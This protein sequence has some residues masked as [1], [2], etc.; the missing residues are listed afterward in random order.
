M[1]TASESMPTN[2]LTGDLPRLQSLAEAEQ[3]SYDL[4]STVKEA[5]IE[6][7]MA[8]S[9]NH[10]DGE[11][12]A[13]MLEAVEDITWPDNFYIPSAWK[14][15]IEQCLSLDPA[16]RPAD[17]REVWSR[18][19]ER[20]H[21]RVVRRARRL[22]AIFALLLVAA[23]WATIFA[24]IQAGRAKE[25]SREAVT[26]RDQAE[27]LALIIIDE[28]NRGNLSG[29]EA[30][31]LY[32]LI[33]DHSETFLAN[34]PKNNQS[35]TTLKWSA[36]T[37]SMR[38]RQAFE[39]G[40]LDEALE[41]YTNAYEIRSQLGGRRLGLLGAR[42]LMQIGRIHELKGDYDSAVTSYLKAKEWRLNDFRESS[43][44]TTQNIRELSSTYL[45]LGNLYQKTGEKKK[46]T[47]ILEEV[48][49]IL[50]G[51]SNNAP[52][53]QKLSFQRELMPVLARLGEIHYQNDELKE[54]F[55]T[56]TDLTTMAN[57][58]SSTSPTLTEEARNHYLTATHYLGQIQL[59]R[60]EIG[61]ALL[62]FRNEIKLRNQ[63]I[64]RRPYD[65]DLKIGLA[66]AYMKASEC[67]NIEDRTKRSLGIFYLEQALSLIS[68]LPPDIRNEEF[69]VSRTIQYQEKLNSML[70]KDE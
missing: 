2:S 33:A 46:A 64:S 68:S 38:G 43:G 47:D 35:E 34:L 63:I 18:I 51:T 30:N 36:Q 31:K 65:P 54:A 5:T 58:I 27:Q 52:D 3:A 19:Q 61:E 23:I 60:D 8:E 24:F 66:D 20:D 13:T 45:A 10:L 59:D 62:L 53:K 41:K 4:D 48:T 37:A 6:A 44:I 16:K 14:M 29:S 26:S 12:L 1:S 15:L 50:N 32:T 67:L 17:M 11:N 39:N 7:T 49:A 56:F 70:E 28:L 69:N 57:Q 42:D 25:A 22:N 21:Y 55:E 40:E 9:G